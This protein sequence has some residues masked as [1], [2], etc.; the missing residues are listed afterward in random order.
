ME[1]RLFIKGLGAITLITALPFTDALALDG[2]HHVDP[3]RDGRPKK[4]HNYAMVIVQNRCIGCKACELSCKKTWNLSE[5]PENYRT[6][7]I[8][9]GKAQSFNY[10]RSWMPVLCNQCDNPPCVSVCPTSASYKREEDGIILVDPKKCIGCKT[11]MAG[12][13]YDARYYDERIHS[14]DKCTFCQPRL[15][16]GLE[17]ACVENCLMGARVFGDLNDPESDVSKLLRKAMSY[18]VL[19]PEEGT[20]CNVFYTTRT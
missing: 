14:V 7:V 15:E 12:C 4:K 1:R 10:R 20:K 17:P 13:P 18:H 16:K 2:Y 3:V 5:K 8:Y 9:I 11:C 6:K 19:K